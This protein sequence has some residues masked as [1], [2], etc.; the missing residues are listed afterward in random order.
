MNPKWE[1]VVHIPELNAM[2]AGQIPVLNAMAAGQDPC[3]WMLW[4]VRPLSAPPATECYGSVTWMQPIAFSCRLRDLHYSIDLGRN[5]QLP[6]GEYATLLEK[7]ASSG[8][9]IEF[10][11]TEDWNFLVER[12]SSKLADTITFQLEDSIQFAWEKFS[13]SN[14]RMPFFLR[15][16]QLLAGELRST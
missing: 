1:G 15:K 8:R 4:Q 6:V 14:R 3:T 13:T 7:V 9:T 11:P 2:V 12:L 5:S 10:H 16:I